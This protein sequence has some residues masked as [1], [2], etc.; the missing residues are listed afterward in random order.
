MKVRHRDWCKQRRKK[1]LDLSQKSDDQDLEIRTL[2]YF[3]ERNFSDTGFE[4]KLARRIKDTSPIAARSSKV[5]SRILSAWNVASGGGFDTGIEPA[6][7]VPRNRPSLTK[8]LHPKP[9]AIGDPEM[10][11]WKP[12]DSSR[13]KKRSG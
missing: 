1:L 8:D 5:C 9:G 11:G 4:A 13:V 7:L 10:G 12:L 2:S 6:K 3:I